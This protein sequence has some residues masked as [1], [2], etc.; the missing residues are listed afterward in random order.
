VATGGGLLAAARYLEHQSLIGPVSTVTSVAAPV[1][2][3]TLALFAIWT[4]LVGEQDPFH[5]ALLVAAGAVLLL[6]VLLASWGVSMAG[7]LVVVACAPIVTVIGFETVGH[8]HLTE[9][10]ERLRPREAV[11]DP[12][13]AVR[14]EA[15]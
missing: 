15:T 13:A 14:S 9:A 11:H 4:T 6:S 12:D 1:A 5:L 8:R 7:C 3:F 10:M 2:V